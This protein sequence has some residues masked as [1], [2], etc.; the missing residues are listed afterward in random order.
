LQR[1]ELL[2][3]CTLGIGALERPSRGRSRR[4][5]ADGQSAAGGEAGTPPT[6]AGR[7]AGE[8]ERLSSRCQAAG[9][10]VERALDP[11]E[12]ARV[13]GS[14]T[15][16]DGAAGR[17]GRWPWPLGVSEEWGCLRTDG[18]WHATYWIAEWPRSEVAGDFL[19][20]LLV[21]SWARRSVA[22]VMAPR[23]AQRAVRA[24]E[25]A[26]TEKAAAAEL[27]RRHGFALTARLQREQEAVERR[28]H[29]LAAG[30]V[31]YRFSG[32]VTVTAGDPSAL[33]DACR[34]VE[35]AAA[36]ARLELRRLYGSQAEAFC[37]TLPTGRG[38][39]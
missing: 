38:C 1:H 33:A 10:V 19:L 23:P 29:E 7:L 5:L 21:G 30:H 32:Y 16:L 31:A 13:V 15:A 22:L 12:L 11:A 37:C 27:R 35:Q 9:I 26:R 14:S 8:I 39:Q 3:A 18:T 34:S 4:W 17:S 6:A 28:E 2:L 24:A 25:Q 36:L 20:P